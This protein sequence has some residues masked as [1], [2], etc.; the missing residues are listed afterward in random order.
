VQSVTVKQG[1]SAFI[2]VFAP[3]TAYTAEIVLKAAA[4]YKFSGFIIPGTGGVGTPA[5]GTIGGGDVAQNTLTF[6]VNFPATTVGI[7]P[8]GKIITA[9]VTDHAINASASAV[10]VSRSAVSPAN[11][12]TITVTPGSG[13]TAYA[14]TVGGVTQTTATGAAYTFDAA[15][16]SNGNYTIGLVITKGTGAAAVRYSKEF[17][18]T[19]TN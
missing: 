6:I 14:W 5:A 12:V 8:A 9:W 11:R 10:T 16:R 3:L 4:N 18:I 13:Y 7:V 17:T 1:A 2:G 15:W 19:V